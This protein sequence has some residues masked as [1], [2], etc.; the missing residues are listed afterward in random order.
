MMYV[1][2]KYIAMYSLLCMHGIAV[3]I[4][5]LRDILVVRLVEFIRKLPLIYTSVLDLELLR[6]RGFT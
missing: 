3:Y 5:Y 6:R 2:A 1:H 4:A